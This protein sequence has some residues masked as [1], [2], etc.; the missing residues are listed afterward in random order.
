[1]NNPKVLQKQSDY[2]RDYSELFGEVHTTHCDEDQGT[3]LPEVGSFILPDIKQPLDN[4]LFFGK[5]LEE[6][7]GI[8]RGHNL[9]RLID[10]N[11]KRPRRSSPVARNWQT[12]SI[13]IQE[14]LSESMSVAIYERIKKRGYRIKLADEFMMNARI[15]L[16]DQGMASVSRVTDRVLNIRRCDF[17]TIPKFVK[18]VRE[19]YERCRE[20]GLDVKP[21]LVLSRMFGEL[22]RDIPTFIERKTAEV[23]ARGDGDVWNN[24]TADDIFEICD[25][26]LR[27]VK[28]I[29]IQYPNVDI[30]RLGC[31]LIM[32]APAGTHR[33][34][35][36]L[37]SKS[38]LISLVECFFFLA[39]MLVL[40]DWRWSGVR[41]GVGILLGEGIWLTEFVES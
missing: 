23:D 35:C 28:G 6:V 31:E 10:I 36:S 18:A 8:L 4:N 20:V 24:V 22:R 29:L 33:K 12:I 7:H 1:M 39:R 16:Q 2:D 11:I 25:S 34:E 3:D 15:T 5:W 37:A 19:R 26:I 21:Y 9:H 38:R 32:I 27:N 13:Q 41:S 40:Y 17:N 14:W 30:A